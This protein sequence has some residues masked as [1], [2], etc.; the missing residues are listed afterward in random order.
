[1]YGERLNMLDLRIGKI[2]QF[3]PSRAIVSIDLYNALNNS[4]VITVSNAYDTWLQPQ[5]ILTARFVKI[6]MQFDF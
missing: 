4:T 6:G 1:M 3:G 2:L 5:S